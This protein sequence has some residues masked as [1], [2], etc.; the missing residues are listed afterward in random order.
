MSTQSSGIDPEVLEKI[1]RH[2]GITGAPAE[3]FGSLGVNRLYDRETRTFT[4]IP[5][6]VH[7]RRVRQCMSILEKCRG[8]IFADH[9]HQLEAVIQGHEIITAELLFV[10]VRRASALQKSGIPPIFTEEF[11]PPIYGENIA[12]GKRQDSAG[13][14]FP[15]MDFIIQFATGR[16]ERQ[17]RATAARMRDAGD[18]IR[19]LATIPIQPATSRD[20]QEFC[21]VAFTPDRRIDPTL[22]RDAALYVTVHFNLQSADASAHICLRDQK[23]FAFLEKMLAPMCTPRTYNPWDGNNVRGIVSSRRWYLSFSRQDRIQIARAF[24]AA[25]PKR[26]LLPDRLLRDGLYCLFPELTGV[27]E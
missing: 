15:I 27:N 13:G 8:Y 16:F 7:E 25:L 2:G 20:V 10:I 14:R 21:Q 24:L 9:L 22:I 1:R 12:C 6:R 17:R 18:R 4:V 19:R 23:A 11:C 3:L 5:Q 26:P